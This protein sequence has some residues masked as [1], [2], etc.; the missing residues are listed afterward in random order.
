LNIKGRVLVVIIVV[1]IAVAAVLITP[2]ALAGNFNLKVTKVSFT[3]NNSGTAITFGKQL[4]SNST[5]TPTAYE[6]YF[7]LRSGGSITSS[8]NNVNSTAGSTNSTISWRLYNPSN[9]TVSQGNYVF[10]GGLGNRTHTFTFAVDQGVR[11]SGTY[12]LFIFE[13]AAAV[14]LSLT[15]VHN[16]AQ[17]TQY[18]WKVP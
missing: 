5:T 1:I 14:K 6:Y 18:T 4:T 12:R 3:E 8:N 9:Q 10:S 15:S 11:D 7:L 13:Q 2:V 16:L 17:T